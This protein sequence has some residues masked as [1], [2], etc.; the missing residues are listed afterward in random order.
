MRK[1]YA[2][3][4]SSSGIQKFR[5]EDPH[6]FLQNEY[7]DDF[8]L[9]F[10]SVKDFVSQ[11][12]EA[13]S[14]LFLHNSVL[15][16]DTTLAR[17][18]SIKQQ[19]QVKIIVDV[20]DYWVFPP[21]HALK[22]Y[23][24]RINLKQRIKDVTQMA[25]LVTCTTPFL[26]EK[27]SAFSKNVVVVENSI[28]LG[29]KQFTSNKTTSDKIRIGYVAGSSHLEDVALLRGLFSAVQRQHPNTEFYLC[30]FDNRSKEIATGK[31][32]LVG[33]GSIWHQM[34][35][36]FTDKYAGLPMRYVEYLHKFD[37]LSESPIQPYRR[38]WTKPV[39][40]YAMSYNDID[41]ALAPLIKNDYN[42][43]KSELKMIEAGLHKCAIVCSDTVPYNIV[44]R[45][46][47][48]CLIVPD[49]KKHKA[50][51]QYVCRL[52]EDAELRNRLAVQLHHDITQN[53]DLKKI[54]QKRKLFYEN[55]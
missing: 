26:K 31:I 12:L 33:E 19:Q 5:I 53:Y 6:V 25:D 46:E 44:G 38:I 35:M 48:N 7:P 42:D 15:Q 29:E 41:I 21:N 32:K 30:G 17:L 10:L 43:C 11:P 4:Q 52:V 22:K 55:L 45:H 50:W 20:D 9:N 54:T 27:L 36:I 39:K 8:E 3:Q 23:A 28:N 40:E 24:D 13:G 47:E 34:E 1:I 51:I 37:G 16:D 14:L 49:N 2:V 18:K